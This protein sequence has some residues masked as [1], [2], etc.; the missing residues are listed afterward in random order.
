MTH[1][2]DR[3]PAPRYARHGA[4]G[5]TLIEIMVVVLII[6]L[7]AAVIVP[8][9]VSKVGEARVAKAK[10]DIQSLE[11]ALTEYRLD[12]S[13]YPTTDQ[14]LEALLQKPNDPTLSNWHGPYVQRLSL[15]PWGHAYH[16]VYPGT[17]GLPYDLYTLG[18]N[19]QPGG[20]G[21]NAEIGNWNLSN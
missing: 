21:D 20:S 8:E 3:L 10:E 7:L 19:N 11:T 6:G 5:F 15:D 12:N 4:R 2:V 18:A 14:G 1:R 13:V 9:V 16:Y 17:H